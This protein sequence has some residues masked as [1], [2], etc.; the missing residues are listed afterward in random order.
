MPCIVLILLS[1]AILALTATAAPAARQP[2]LDFGL[3]QPV[4]G[5]R[6]RKQQMPLR[7]NVSSCHASDCECYG[8]KAAT[9]EYANAREAKKAGYHTCK[10]CEGREGA[11]VG[12]KQDKAAAA[13]L[14]GNPE[15]KTLH[16][17]S[18]RHC[19]SRG[20]TE[21]F[22]SAEQAR[23]QGCHLC[24]LCEGKQPL[25]LAVPVIFYRHP[26]AQRR[27]PPVL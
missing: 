23:K 25:R 3:Q 13:R 24:K 14:R 6:A 19:N 20:S 16:G 22:S 11:A 8:S 26:P 1:L 7:G 5:V 9:A 21:A 4:W 2:A 10:T 12:K 15:S 27:P 17:P 18:C